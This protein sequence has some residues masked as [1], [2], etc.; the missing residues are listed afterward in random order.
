MIRFARLCSYVGYFAHRTALY[1]S[2][3]VGVGFSEHRLWGT[4]VRRLPSLSWRYGFSSSRL[5][6][7]I[8]EHSRELPG[9]GGCG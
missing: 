4:V 6:E 1:I 5:L 7:L 9:V 3:M 2:S 8:R